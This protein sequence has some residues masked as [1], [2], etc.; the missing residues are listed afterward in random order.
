MSLQAKLQVVTSEFQKLQIDLS[1]AVEARQRLEAQLSENQ[2][3]KKEFDQL[4]PE[5][6]VYKQIGPVL[7]KQDQ[8]EA[9]SN[10]DTRL[11]FITGE[12]KRVESQIKEIEQKSEKKKTEVL[13]FQ[14]SMQQQQ[15]KASQPAIKA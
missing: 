4:K 7:V 14:T 6:V 3:V 8:S 11:E 2:L 10:V 13:E 9:K 12:I 5:S 15:A 1:N